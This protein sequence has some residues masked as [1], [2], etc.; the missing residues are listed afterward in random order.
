[1]GFIHALFLPLIHL[2]ILVISTIELW[3]GFVKYLSEF[4]QGFQGFFEIQIRRLL[5]EP[6]SQLLISIIMTMKQLV[7]LF[8]LIFRIG[9]NLCGQRLKCI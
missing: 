1:M 7:Y 9:V 5:R 3:I 2:Y 4:G 8:S 6:G